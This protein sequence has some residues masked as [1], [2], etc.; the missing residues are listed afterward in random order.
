MRAFLLLWA[1]LLSA[2]SFAQSS[3]QASE[4]PP[5]ASTEARE[6]APDD[7]DPEDSPLVRA[8]KESRARNKK[9][10]PRVVLTNE[11]ARKAK[12]GLILISEKPIEKKSGPKPNPQSQRQAP[13][14]PTAED[15]AAANAKLE[16]ARK[17]VSD[18]EKE[19]GRLE[20]DY[21]N[22]DDPNYRDRVIEARFQQ[23]TRQLAIARQKLL[24]AREQQQKIEQV[25]AT[26]RP[27][28]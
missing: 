28:N 3:S 24:D 10:P 14:G 6:L 19:L 5:K 17:E 9:S 23:A 22:E 15:L 18:L 8:A 11:D 21:Y 16:A 2:A 27:S 4:A 20:E 25:Q 1:F 7:P 12:G 13:T 26:R